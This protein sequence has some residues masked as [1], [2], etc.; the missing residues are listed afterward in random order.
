VRTFPGGPGH[1]ARSISCRSAECPMCRKAARCGRLLST[2]APPRIDGRR[3]AKARGLALSRSCVPAAARAIKSP[4]P[5]ARPAIAGRWPR[6]LGRW[7]NCPT[8]LGR[9]AD[10]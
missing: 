8:G 6:G 5:P 10:V 9:N 2:N 4:K 7:P 3:A 1:L